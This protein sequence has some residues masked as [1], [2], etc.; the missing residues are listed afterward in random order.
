M[1]EDSELPAAGDSVVLV[2]IPPGLL[3]G[4]PE[5]DQRAIRAA[6]GK[7]VMLVGYDNGGRAE[8]YFA[9]PFTV[10][11]DESSHTHKIWVATEFIERCRT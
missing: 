7:P 10:Q 3:D 8:L 1:D 2:A 5:E 4:L 9:D 11:T 6:V